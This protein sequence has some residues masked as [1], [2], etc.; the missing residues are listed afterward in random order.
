[1]DH[2]CTWESGKR[3]REGGELIK[4]KEKSS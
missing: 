1:L 3:G 4:Y 2:M